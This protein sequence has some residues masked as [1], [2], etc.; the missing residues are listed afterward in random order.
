MK[1]NFNSNI[2]LIYK[3]SEKYNK[4]CNTISPILD[5]SLKMNDKS[6]HFNIEDDINLTK[7]ILKHYDNTPIGNILNE[8]IKEEEH[9][10]QLEREIQIREKIKK[11]Y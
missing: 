4:K 9:K 7:F 2:P 11:F 8:I 3:I 10:K 5:I 1:N 6:V